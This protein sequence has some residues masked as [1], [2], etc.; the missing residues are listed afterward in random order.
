MPKPKPEPSAPDMTYDDVATYLNIT[1]RCA[2]K[3]VATGELIAYKLG[4]RL[5]RF[6]KSD[7]DNALQPT[8]EF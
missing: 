7:I 3:K 8:E 6:R 2:R 5:V 4:P 1:T